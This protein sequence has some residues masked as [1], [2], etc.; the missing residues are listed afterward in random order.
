MYCPSIGGVFDRILAMSFVLA[1]VH[2]VTFSCCLLFLAFN[3]RPL[4]LRSRSI[5]LDVACWVWLLL[6]ARRAIG[7]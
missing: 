4:V 7:E 1:I 6:M 2:L 3:M 5:N